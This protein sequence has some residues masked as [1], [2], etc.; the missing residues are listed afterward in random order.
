ME[1]IC[2]LEYFIFIHFC[3]F[4]ITCGLSNT[5]SLPDGFVN[6]E[7]IR[8][9]WISVNRMEYE[10][11]GTFHVWSNDNF[12]RAM[13]RFI[14]NMEIKLS[15]IYRRES[16]PIS[17]LDNDQITLG[18]NRCF[19]RRKGVKKRKRKIGRS[20]KARYGCRTSNNRATLSPVSLGREPPILELYQRVLGRREK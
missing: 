20:E 7:T 11:C 15:R 9:P 18:Q 12:I 3:R 4:S 16:D 2:I 10:L 14:R 17:K 5:Y 13:T 6:I 19:H 8:F 1:Y